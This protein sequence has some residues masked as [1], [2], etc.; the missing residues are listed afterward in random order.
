MRNIAIINTCDFGSTGKIAKG[1][2]TYL[3]EHSYNTYFYYG[4]GEISSDSHQMRIDTPLEVKFHALK[5]RLTGYQGSGS[6]RATKKL[7]ENLSSQKIDTVFCINLHGYYLNEKMFW[8]YIAEKQIKVVYLMA[9]EYAYLGKCTNVV[10]CTK[11]TYG[12]TGCPAVS[13]YPKSWFRDRASEI[14]EMKKQAYNEANNIVFIGPRYVVNNAKASKMMEHKNVVALDETIDVELFSPKNANGLR[15]EL[16]ISKEKIIIVCIAPSNNPS[17][18]SR[19]F[20]ELAELFENDDRYIFIHVAYV[21]NKENLPSNLIVEGYVRDQNRLAEYYSLADL[22]VFP[23]LVDTMPNACLESLACGTPI[24]CFDIS[25]MPFVAD[26]TTG[27]FVE[28]GSIK[29][30][31]DVII[32]TE[33][34]SQETIDT[35]RTYALGRYDNREYFSKIEK[36]ALDM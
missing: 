16:Q 1:L 17:K 35:C 2:Y 24:L 29:E 14:Y 34:K 8:D 12:C 22:F 6:K 30:L 27:K 5:T 32:N 11:Y 20:V 28:A 9:D 10:N 3:T 19:Y 4:R 31:Q 26:D 18:G 13:R 15:N 33:K 7:V 23:S 36:I 21:G 25:G